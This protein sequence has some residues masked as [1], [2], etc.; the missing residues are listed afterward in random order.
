MLRP[1]APASAAFDDASLLEV[2]APP[3]TP[4]VTATATRVPAT[5]TPTRTAAPSS[6][7]AAPGGGGSG[8]NGPRGFAGP[9]AAATGGATVRIN[10]VL[11]DPVDE[12]DNRHEWVEL[13]NFGDQAAEI[14]GWMIE[15]GVSSDLLPSFTIPAGGY[16]LVAGGDYQ[17][18][19][20]VLVVRP[21]DGRIG[22]GLNNSGDRI[23][24]RDGSGAIVDA[25]A[26]GDAGEAGGAPPAPS[27]G[28]TIGFNDLQQRWA[29][30]VRATPGEANLFPD[31]PTPVATATGVRPASTTAPGDNAE[32]EPARGDDDP[33]VIEADGGGIS[34]LALL[35]AGAAGGAGLL[36]GGSRLLRMVEGRRR[37]NGR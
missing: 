25:L 22:Q 10:E 3:P 2:E 8:A 31:E 23:V 20:G 33:G 21:A 15:D 4:T 7:V 27:A 30:T 11:S 35:I 14:V 29:T 37:P 36:A 16:A 34:P 13:Y 9:G 12:P 28:K 26:Y 5:S 32:G 1:F 6:P 18:P 17:A 19:A 24:L